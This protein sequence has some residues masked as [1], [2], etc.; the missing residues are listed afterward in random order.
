MLQCIVMFY[1]RIMCIIYLLVSTNKKKNILLKTSDERMWWISLGYFHYLLSCSFFFFLFDLT[2]YIVHCMSSLFAFNEQHQRMRRF[3]LWFPLL[4]AF[5]WIFARTKLKRANQCKIQHKT[6]FI[7]YKK[8]ALNLLC[9]ITVITQFFFLYEYWKCN[10]EQKKMR[11]HLTLLTEQEYRF[12][13]WKNMYIKSVKNFQHWCQIWNSAFRISTVD[14]P[15]ARSLLPFHMTLRLSF[16]DFHVS[17]SD[18]CGWIHFMFATFNKYR[19]NITVINT[20]NNIIVSN[21]YIYLNSSFQEL[22]PLNGF[23]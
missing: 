11:I 6:T 8:C 10:S 21:K 20:A 23:W 4:R 15:E 1:I 16:V 19:W 18:F 13:Y 9:K 14:H 22:F 3:A 2:G 17:K 7:V 12:Y 5:L